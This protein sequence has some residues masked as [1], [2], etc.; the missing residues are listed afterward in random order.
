MRGKREIC[1][2]RD[3]RVKSFRVYGA[4]EQ[5]VGKRVRNRRLGGVKK[6]VATCKPEFKDRLKLDWPAGTLRLLSAP[7]DST[8]ELLG[9][10][11]RVG[12]DVAQLEEERALQADS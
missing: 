12:L 10:W 8:G 7:G 4:V 5:E 9:R 1:Q 11:G 6:A 2:Q 3:I